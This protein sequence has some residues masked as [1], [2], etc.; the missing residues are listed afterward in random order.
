ASGRT[1]IHHFDVFE[2]IG[3]FGFF[4]ALPKVLAWRSA[5]STRESVKSAV[6]ENYHD[7]LARFLRQ[8]KSALSAR[9]EMQI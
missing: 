3:D 9:A 4:E 2:L 5:L 7:L 1:L 8:R 6:S